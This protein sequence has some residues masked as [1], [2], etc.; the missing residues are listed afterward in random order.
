MIT[1]LIDKEKPPQQN[2]SGR[3]EPESPVAA[4]DVSEQQTPEQNMVTYIKSEIARLINRPA[5]A[6][7][8]WKGFYD[9]GLDSAHLLKLVKILEQT[10]QQQF[11]PTLLF[12][13]SSVRRL[14]DYLINEAG[15]VLKD[16]AEERHTSDAD[17]AD[18]VLFLN[19]PGK[20][21]RWKRRC[22]TGKNTP[23]ISLS[24]PMQEPVSP[25]NSAHIARKRK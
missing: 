9:M 11:Y 16:S 15:C 3:G 17:I 13:Y 14:A 22:R 18:E 23:V 19:P 6:I 21:I 7:D 1:H 25:V 5:Q 8:V 24:L 12:E 4:E 10:F 2:R 20:I